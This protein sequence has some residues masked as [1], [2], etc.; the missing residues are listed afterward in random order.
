VRF[1]VG[2]KFMNIDLARLLDECFSRA[3]PP[4]E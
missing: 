4:L 3:R 1:T 2:A